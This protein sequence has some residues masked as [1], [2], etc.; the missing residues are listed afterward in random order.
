MRRSLI[1]GVVMALA[2]LAAVPAVLADNTQLNF[3]AHLTGEDAGADTAG[4]GQGIVRFSTDV[5]TMD[6]RLNVANIENVTMAHIHVSATPGGDGPPVVWLYPDGPPPTLI[7]GR[8]QGTIGAGTVTA[9]DLVGPLAGQD[10][11][12]LRTAIVEGRAY[13]NVHTTQYPAGEI[14]GQL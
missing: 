11:E 6:F 10:L 4:Q 7:E 14:R 5:D 3:R 13:F 8:V 12:A 1:V 9:A 2:V